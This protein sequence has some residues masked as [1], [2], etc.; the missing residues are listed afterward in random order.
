MNIAVK[1][2]LTKSEISEILLLNDICNL[3]DRTH[4]KPKLSTDL[5]IS[6]SIPTFFLGRE[7]DILV[8]FLTVFMPEGGIPE[9]TA[10]VHPTYRRQRRFS[11][12]FNV[13]KT[14]YKGYGFNEFI[15]PIN[16]LSLDGNK[17]AEKF[18]GLELHHRNYI[19]ELDSYVS[20]IKENPLEIKEVTRELIPDLSDAIKECSDSYLVINSFKNGIGSP[21]RTSYVAYM[22]DKP[23]GFF[24]VYHNEE[25]EEFY[26]VSIR[27]PLREKGLGKMML[28]AAVKKVLENEKAIIAHVD[29]ENP[30]AYHIYTTL[31][32]MRTERNDYYIYK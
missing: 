27:K 9:I 18:A 23:V 17:A 11:E 5:N 26:G 32:F 3:V 10:F 25:S 2:N 30:A 1:N 15:F 31:G 21:D 14:L 24:S 28:S 29:S 13:M 6:K 4:S 8:A 16:S 12:I 20:R 7:D 22:Y 19:M